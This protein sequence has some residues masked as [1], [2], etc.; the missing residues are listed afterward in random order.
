MNLNH[1]NY[2]LIRILIIMKKNKLFVRLDILSLTFLCYNRYY[3][4]KKEEN[5]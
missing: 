1:Y 2:I 3:N 5:I 4:V